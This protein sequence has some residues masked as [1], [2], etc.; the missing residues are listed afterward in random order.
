MLWDEGGA[1]GERDTG[2]GTRTALVARADQAERLRFPGG[3][4]M[5]LLADG[6]ETRGALGVHQ[7]VLRDAG[8]G[9]SPHHHLHATEVFHV[10]RG[11]VQL[12]LGDDLVEVGAGDLVVVPPGAVHAF[13]AAPGRDAELL[14]V[15]TP[16][17]ERFSLFRRFEAVSTGRAPAATVLADQSTYDTYADTS[18]V[19]DRARH[20]IDTKETP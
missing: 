19:W 13:A 15:V 4:T 18:E 5:T 7:A 17:I 10:L 6:P 16:G 11:G 14:V 9:A 1:M 12:L 20:H 8:V 2:E 3:S